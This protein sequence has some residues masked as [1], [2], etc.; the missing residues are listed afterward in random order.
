[1]PKATGLAPARSVSRSVMPEAGH[2]QPRTLPRTPPPPEKPGHVYKP[3]THERYHREPIPARSGGAL[4]RGSTARATRSVRIAVAALRRCRSVPPSTLSR[5]VRVM[6]LLCS[7]W[8]RGEAPSW[9]GPPPAGVMVVVG[10]PGL[11]EAGARGG[12]LAGHT[13]AWGTGPR[14]EG[15]AAPPRVLFACDAPTRAL[16]EGNG[17]KWAGPTRRAW[18]GAERAASSEPCTAG[19]GGWWALMVRDRACRLGLRFP[20]AA[21]GWWERVTGGRNV[22]RTPGL[23]LGPGRRL[24]AGQSAAGA[25]DGGPR[26]FGWQATRSRSPLGGA[27]APLLLHTDL[28]TRSTRLITKKCYKKTRP[29]SPVRLWRCAMNEVAVGVGVVMEAAMCGQMIRPPYPESTK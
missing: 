4:S 20:A 8:R 28:R 10:R 24:W 6:G 15:V 23:D 1:M 29:R 7:R 16:V 2:R 27:A 19:V 22:S 14:G 5:N 21:R 11:G 17:G 26:V 25:R 18:R 13:A 9:S 12:A 3:T